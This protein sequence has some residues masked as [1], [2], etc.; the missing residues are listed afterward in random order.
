NRERA[1]FV[2]VNVRLYELAAFTVAGIFA[3]FSGALFGI[4]NRG[5]FADY[6]F[7]SKSAD[8]MIM[9]ILGGMNHFWGPAVG[10]AVL[11][12]LNQQITSY[13]QYRPFV[14]R[15]ILVLLLFVFPRGVQ[16]P[17]GGPPAPPDAPP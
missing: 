12:I 9:T 6:V 11:T 3:G 2:G 5:V 14:L 4:F 10:A 17:P 15:T 16:G 8:V 1:A 7:W 13:T